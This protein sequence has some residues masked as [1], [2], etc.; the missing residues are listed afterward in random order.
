MSQPVTSARDVFDN[1]ASSSTSEEPPN[2]AS[3]E[4]G[5]TGQKNLN[6]NITFQYTEKLRYQSGY[7]ERERMFCRSSTSRSSTHRKRLL[8][9]GFGKRPEA[10]E[11]RRSSRHP[12]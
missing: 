10:R 11:L 1:G 3:A 7:L 4:E 8:D 12:I 6:I 2:T 5:R 9:A